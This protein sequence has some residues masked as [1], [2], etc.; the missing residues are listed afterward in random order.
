MSLER[1]AVHQNNIQ[2]DWKLKLTTLCEHK[3]LE[4]ASGNFQYLS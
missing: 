1:S 3:K 2:F 4:R